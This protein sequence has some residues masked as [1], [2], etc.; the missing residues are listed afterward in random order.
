MDLQEVACGLLSVFCV[1]VRTVGACAMYCVA[2]G[3]CHWVI[4]LFCWSMLVI[5]ILLQCSVVSVVL[6]SVLS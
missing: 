4:V 3:F 2:E 5:V 6:C 1:V